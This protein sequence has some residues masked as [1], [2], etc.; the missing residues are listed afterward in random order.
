MP[1]SQTTTRPWKAWL[2]VLPLAVAAAIWAVPHLLHPE[3]KA[4][5]EAEGEAGKKAGVVQLAPADLAMVSLQTVPETIRATGTFEPFPEG[6][7]SVAV[8]VAGRLLDLSLKPGDR[9]QAGQVVARVLRND[10]EAES[11]KADAVVAEAQ[12]EV[13]ALQ[14]QLPLQAGTLEAQARQAQSARAQAQARLDRLRKGSRPEEIQRAEAQLAAAQADLE[15]L[16][17]GPR[18]QEVRQGEAVLR[19]A[20][21]EVE[22]ARKKAI[23][24]RALVETGVMAAKDRDRADADLAQAEARAASAREALSI[25]HQGT[26]P[27]ELRAQEAKVRDAQAQL[28]LVRQGPRPEE[29]REA[30]ADVGQT[31]AKQAEVAAQRRQADI[32]RA[33]I[34]AARERLRAAQAAANAARSIRAQAVVRAPISGVVEKVVAARGEVVQAGAHLAELQSRDSLRLLVQ[35]PAAYQARV[36]VGTAVAITVPDQPGLR[37]QGTVQVIDPTVQPETGTLTAEVWLPNADHRLRAGTLATVDVLLQKGVARPLIPAQAVLSRDGEQFVYRL[38]DDGKIHETRVTLG[39]E[40]EGTVQVLTGVRPGERILRDGSRSIAD[41][42]PYQGVPG[43]KP[44]AAEHEEE[45]LKG[46]KADRD[47]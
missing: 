35:V 45:H 9:V 38:E 29:I 20:S 25:L 32:T 14:G 16:K 36:R 21:A 2:L 22:V 17:N 44:T 7:A 43:A 37:R 27:E 33:Q 1:L 42:S 13:S 12:R 34:Q 3:V 6:R 41:G 30:E 39:P 11:Q 4:G 40:K 26:R 18:P 5:D 15:R 24:A 10:L 19:E 23:R 46:K 31:E 8:E 28:A 47:E